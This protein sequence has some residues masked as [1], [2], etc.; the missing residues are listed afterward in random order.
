MIDDKQKTPQWDHMK[1][2]DATEQQVIASRAERNQQKKRKSGATEEQ[3]AKSRIWVQI[4]LFP[5]WV[6]IIIVVA[7]LATAAVLGAMVG[8]GYIGDGQPSEVL[9]KDTWTHII[10]IISGKES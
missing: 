5:I 1:R 3:S 10:D 9:K 7:I 8:Y 6:R 4:R 2:K